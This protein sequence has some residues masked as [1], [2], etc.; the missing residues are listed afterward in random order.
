MVRVTRAP[1]RRKRIKKLLKQAR[2]FRGDRKN[3]HVLA[4]TALM[5]AWAYAFRGRKEKKREFRSLWIQRIN[6][7]ARVHGISYSRLIDG[8]AKAKVDVNRKMLAML[9]VEDTHAF[10]AIV[11]QAK[12]ALVA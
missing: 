8:L 10:G 3:H 1:A 4:H 6:A 7:A 12:K 5:K 2:G 11:E 9:A